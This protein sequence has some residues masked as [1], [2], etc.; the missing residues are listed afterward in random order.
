M[1]KSFLPSLHPDFYFFFF[2]LCI[3]K[4]CWEEY[5]FW[6]LWLNTWASGHAWAYDVPYI[7]ATGTL[8]TMTGSYPST[9]WSSKTFD[10]IW[11]SFTFTYQNVIMLTINLTAFYKDGNVRSQVHVLFKLFSYCTINVRIAFI[12]QFQLGGM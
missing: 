12:G 7:S 5:T 8:K 1:F 6:L 3:W 10:C 4:E 2:L 11:V 9:V